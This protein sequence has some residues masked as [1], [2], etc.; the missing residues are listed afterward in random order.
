MKDYKNAYCIE[1]EYFTCPE[2][3]SPIIEKEHGESPEIIPQDLPLSTKDYK[4]STMS[5]K[6]YKL[7]EIFS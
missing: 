3:D 5:K 2:T 6:T 7:Y 4:K 1:G